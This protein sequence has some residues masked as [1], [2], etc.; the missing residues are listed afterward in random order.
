LEVKT[1]TEGI[2]NFVLV[3]VKLDVREAMAR[4]VTVVRVGQRA[5]YSIKFETMP[6]FCG[7]C[8]FFSHTHLECGSG[9]HDESKLKWEDW[10]KADWETWHGRV[11]GGNRGGARGGR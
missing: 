8:G 1:D 3:R 6:K 9:E 5:F 10:L 11:I 7:A 2:N 4:F